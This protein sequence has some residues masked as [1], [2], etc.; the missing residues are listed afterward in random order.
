MTPISR[1]KL[2]TAAAA[3]GPAAFA[4]QV[5]AQAAGRPITLVVPTPAGGTTD[6][7]ARMLAEPLGKILGLA[8]VVDNRGGANGS[9]A[10]QQVARGPSDGRSLLLQYSGYQCISPLL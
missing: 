2:I 5:L 9:I 3:S 8:V 10:G 7:A 6:I 4:G 1:R